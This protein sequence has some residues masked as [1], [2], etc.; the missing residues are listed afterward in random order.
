MS[1][2]HEIH[3][4]KSALQYIL[5]GVKKH[6]DDL[7]KEFDGSNDKMRIAGMQYAN[8]FLRIAF[9]FPPLSMLFFIYNNFT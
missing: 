4:L 5:N 6:C 7:K 2:S 1:L 3:C 9:F 8:C